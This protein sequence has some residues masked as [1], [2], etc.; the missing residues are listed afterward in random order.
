MLKRVTNIMYWVGDLEKSVQFYEQVGF[1]KLEVESTHASF[2]LGDF[3]IVLVPPRD[4]DQFAKDAMSQAKGEGAY[5]YVEVDD[6][7]A[8]YHELTNKWPTPIERA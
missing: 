5:L 7:D 1:E 2:S 6:V 4:E 8:T 3:K